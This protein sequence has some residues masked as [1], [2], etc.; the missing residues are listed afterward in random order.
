MILDDD[1]EDV[2]IVQ[3]WELAAGESSVEIGLSGELG[4]SAGNAEGDTIF[5]AIGVGAFSNIESAGVGG[6]VGH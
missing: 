5:I 2:T 6:G 1:G 4:A 3:M